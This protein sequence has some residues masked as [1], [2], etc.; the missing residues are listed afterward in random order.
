MAEF[1]LNILLATVPRSCA[2]GFFCALA[3]NGIARPEPPMADSVASCSSSGCRTVRL[4]NSMTP[5][6][7]PPSRIGK[8][9]APRKA[10]LRRD[11]RSARN[12][13]PA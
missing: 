2:G 13:G 8:A 12:S 5:R 10:Y 4:E 7:S 9:M 6:V 3:F 1:S 11:G